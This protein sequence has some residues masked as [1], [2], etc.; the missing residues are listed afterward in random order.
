MNTPSQQY[1]YPPE[2]SQSA[3]PRRKRRIFLWVFLAAQIL[4]IIWIAT[5]AADSG[6]SCQNLSAHA[7]N[8]TKDVAH[9]AVV[10]VQ[11]LAWVVFDIIV[12]G[13]Y[14]IFRLASRRR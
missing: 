12:G 9:G 14:A 3:P 4:F 5:S 6:G 13:G 8:D 10:V 1:G 11:V 7:C 2:A